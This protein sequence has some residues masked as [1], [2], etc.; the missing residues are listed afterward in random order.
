CGNGACEAGESVGNCPGDCCP[1]TDTINV[2]PGESIQTAMDC[3]QSYAR[4]H[5]SGW[6]DHGRG[7]SLYGRVVL[8]PGAHYI[9]SPLCTRGHVRIEAGGATIVRRAGSHLMWVDDNGGGGYNAPAAYWTIVGGVWDANGGGGFSIVHT[10]K[11]VLWDL[12]IRNIG[13]QAHHLEINS[14]GGEYATGVH[15][16]VVHNTTMHGVAAVHRIDDEAINIDYSWAGAAHN[17]ANDGTVTNNVLIR[18]C[19]FYDVPRAVSTHHFQTAGGAPAAKMSGITIEGGSF[20]DID[21]SRA[22]SGG[23]YEN[24]GAIRP[25]G[26]QNV[27]IENVT[28]T[29]CATAI[30][31]YAPADYPTALGPLGSFVIRNNNVV[32]CGRARAAGVN[33]ELVHSSSAASGIDFW[34]VVVTGNTVSGDWVAGGVYFVATWN[35]HNTT[36]TGNHFAP[37]AY[38]LTQEREH[39]KYKAQGPTNTGTW[40]L[41][42]NTISD[43]SIDNS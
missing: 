26:W 11:F 18:D 31:I 25:Y 7:D 40:N 8:L 34:D 37:T 4:A 21:P 5:A 14:S 27:L 2:N 16:V 41:S 12:E 13:Y 20:H 17:T 35:T 10:R 24:D 1:V 43:D 19:R 28:F 3:A 22:E 9:D 42:G 38:S 15:N 23:N 30:S 29:N 39:N 33:V 32:S 6:P 36:I